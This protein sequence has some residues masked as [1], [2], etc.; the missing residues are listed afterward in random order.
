[1]CCSW[2]VCVSVVCSGF[3]L[4]CLTRV[5]SALGFDSTSDIYASLTGAQNRILML[6]E[7]VL[8]YKTPADIFSQSLIAIIDK[9]VM[10]SKHAE[11]KWLL[12]F[13]QQVNKSRVSFA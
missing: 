13:C 4:R 6:S 12:K 10:K 3:F 2:C 5:T 1:M 9:S 7:R 11:I 8:C